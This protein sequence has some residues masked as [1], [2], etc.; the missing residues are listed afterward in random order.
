M[1]DELT[2]SELTAKVGI[3]EDVS[4]LIVV[5]LTSLPFIEGT[6]LGMFGQ[7]GNPPQLLQIC[8]KICFDFR[9][10]SGGM[11]SLRRMQYC[12]TA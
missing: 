5:G 8:L 6:S 10:T 11:D 12:T 7:P 2:V 1:K 3:T 9:A 4:A